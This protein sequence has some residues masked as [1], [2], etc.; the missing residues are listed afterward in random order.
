MREDPA[1]IP[2]RGVFFVHDHREKSGKDGALGEGDDESS[3]EDRGGYFRADVLPPAQKSEIGD[4]GYVMATT[5][6]LELQISRG[7]WVMGSSY[8]VWQKC[9]LSAQSC[10]T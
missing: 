10:C 1:V 8:D 6:P 5:S 7:W 9:P 4:K 3:D 2:K